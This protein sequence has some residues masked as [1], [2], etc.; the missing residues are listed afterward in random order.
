M[1]SGQPRA[2]RAACVNLFSLEE[3]GYG[4][5]Y[6]L[7]DVL[8]FQRTGVMYRDPSSRRI[9]RHRYSPM[10]YVLYSLPGR[11]AVFENPFV[12]PRFVALTSFALCVTVVIVHC[13]HAP[14]TVSGLGCGADV[15]DRQHV[16]LAAS[17]SRR[18]S[19]DLPQSPRDPPPPVA[20]T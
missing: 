1:G 2:P 20:L 9:C 3:T 11:V 12:G 13:A 19:W 16:G 5:S 6:I 18:L 10:V 7:Y 14:A 17:P 15:L 4:D 8:H